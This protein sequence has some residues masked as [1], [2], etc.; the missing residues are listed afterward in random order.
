MCDFRTK[1]SP[2]AE[3]VQGVGMITQVESRRRS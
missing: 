2:T 3:K 1:A